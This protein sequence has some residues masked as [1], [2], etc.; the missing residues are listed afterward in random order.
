MLR[1]VADENIPA[2]ARAL[3]RLVELRLLP[4]RRIDAAA[5][6]DADA[7]LVRSVTR[8]GPELLCDS[9]VKFVASATAGLDHV[10]A[11][12]LAGRGIAFAWAPGSNAES[13]AQYVA[14]AL[15]RIA[16]ERR[17][18]L[19]GRTIGIVGVGQCGSRVERVARALGMKPLLHD[20]PISRV[21]PDFAH[22]PLERLLEAE[23][24]TLHV[25]LI[26]EGADRTRDLISASALAA[27]RPNAVLINASRGGVVDEAALVRAL[28][29]KRLGAAVIDA[30]IGEP[31]IRPELLAR[32]AIGTPHIAGYSTDGKFRGTQM[33][34]R[35]LGL[36]FGLPIPW[37]PADELPPVAD[38]LELQ[39]RGGSLMETLA[40]AVAQAYPIVRDAAALRETLAMPAS[41]ASVRFDELRKRYP[42]RREFSAWRLNIPAAEAALVR[43]AE[44]L[45]FLVSGA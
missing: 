10:D 9:R 11:D 3:P 29:A 43:A 44:G 45:G 2:V 23:F 39:S 1:I 6:R 18:E 22:L 12:W 36:H 31:S 14:A 28:E 41:A 33:I 38:R 4:G 7:L 5:V 20:P 40:D 25:P 30:W 13:V 26:E 37:T 8:V 24:L 21:R 35:A 34:L 15:L 16:R 42:V 19:E 32:A 27:M 17:I